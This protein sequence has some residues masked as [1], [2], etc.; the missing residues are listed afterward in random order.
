MMKIQDEFQR[1]HGRI[2]KLAAIAM[3][4]AGLMACGGGSDTSESVDSGTELTKLSVSMTDAEGDFLTYQVDVTN[5]S[6]VRSN[7]AVVNVLPQTTTIDFA[8]YVE[9]TELLT[10]LDV[11]SGR[12]DSASLS[13]DFSS[14][15]VTV[16]DEE[17]QPIVAEVVDTEGVLVDDID[18]DI[19][20]N[21]ESGFV[22]RPGVPA[23]V[24][25]DFDLDASNTIEIDGDAA[26]VTLEPVLVA[27][28]VLEE[29]KPFRL[30]GL[31]S[32]VD[33]E[34]AAFEMDLRPFRVRS[35]AF[36]S[37]DVQVSET[38]SFEVDGES[39]D[40]EA[41]LAALA[42]KE[43]GTSVITE[44]SWDRE[45]REYVAVTVY[46]GSSV[47]WDQADVLRGTVVAREGDILHVK[48]A[49]IQL[50]EGTF[51]FNDTFSV[52]ISENTALTQR[53]ES[54]VAA[55]Q[56]S[57]GSA[58]YAT[59]EVTGSTFDAT[60]GL[61]R[62]VQSNVAG[63]VV[64]VSPFVVDLNLVNGRR[65]RIYNFSGT[66]T[67]E[68]S[69][70]DPDNY[71][72]NTGTLD[73]SSV[74]LGDP[75]RVRGFVNEFGTAPEDFNAGTLIDAS[76]IRGHMVVNYGLVGSSNAIS[77]ISEEGII[78]SIEDALFR[79]HIVIAGIPVDLTTLDQV[80]VIEAGGERGVYTIL[81]NGR[82]EVYTYYEEFSVALQEMLE[83][84]VTVVRFDAHGYYDRE[85]GTFTTQ[86]IGIIL[87]D[88]NAI[89][90]TIN[91]E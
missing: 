90:E 1:L 20:F 72:V 5:I 61:V 12:Y 42:L 34:N 9:V 55:A 47:P 11:P 38:T 67:S 10:T 28:T 49:T 45:A 69:D 60:E 7:G 66:G 17:G 52:E 89:S 91:E 85:M 4:S 48:G 15:E 43:V 83:E 56:I 16:Q 21:D 82:L 26:T 13:L 24:T 39:L 41:G 31:L 77:A 36:G 18:V 65:V 68:E 19:M 40:A 51:T 75:V 71:E 62:I 64:S 37:A 27:D 46:A 44:G 32:Q 6:L 3:V 80:P 88:N 81:I 35:G 73:T 76:E 25:L 53:G 57:V 59:G 58:I 86:R 30:R 78:F 23:Q 63:T 22:L 50:A 29:A 33:E 87:N 54:E 14:A 70:A 2:A 8:Q 84:G 79:H 74:L